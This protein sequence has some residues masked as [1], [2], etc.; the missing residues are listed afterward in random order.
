MQL[1]YIP[2]II[3]LEE[4]SFSPFSLYIVQLSIVTFLGMK[5]KKRLS[6]VCNVLC[7]MVEQSP[8]DV[9]STIVCLDKQTFV[10]QSTNDHLSFA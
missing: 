7:Q 8:S 5:K 6:M 9:Y 2:L 3:L 10:S 1:N 4:M